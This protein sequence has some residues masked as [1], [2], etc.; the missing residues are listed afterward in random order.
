MASKDAL[1]KLMKL[2][3]ATLI[4]VVSSAMREQYLYK[5]LRDKNI[6]SQKELDDIFSGK[7]LEGK[8]IEENTLLSNDFRKILLEIFEQ[9]KTLTKGEGGE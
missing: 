5:L 8:E 2:N 9:E 6:L 1:N 7:P 4:E 3:A